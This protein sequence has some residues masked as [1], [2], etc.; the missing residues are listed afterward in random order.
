MQ[1]NSSVNKTEN[2]K[3][4]IK[5]LSRTFLIITSLL[6]FYSC[7]NNKKSSNQSDQS[8]LLVIS[9]GAFQGGNGSLSFVV[10]NES[11][12]IDTVRQNFFQEVNGR[13][14]GNLANHISK[15]DKYIYA[16]MNG[17]A[18]VEVI[19]V[20][21]FLSQKV[22][23]GFKSPRQSLSIDND[24][25]LVS[26]WGTNSIYKV[27]LTLGAIVD[28]LKAGIGPEGMVAY[29]SANTISGKKLFVANSGGYGVDS[30]ISVYD[31]DSWTHEVD[32]QVGI[33]PKEILIDSFG[34]VWVLCSGLD[35]YGQGVDRYSSLI[36]IEPLTKTI[37]SDLVNPVLDNNPSRLRINPEGNRL[38]FLQDSY[39]GSVVE[40]DI[41]S[42]SFPTQK[43]I[44]H[45]AYGLAI[46]ESNGNI[47]LL[48][49]LDYQSPGMAIIY[50]KSGVALD[51]S[52]IGLIPAG[53]IT[54][55]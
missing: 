31:I 38:Y 46:D 12:S 5:N 44:N 52:N 37:I 16:V 49:A 18:T 42:T 3:L 47:L 24:I 29:S 15:D 21:S 36:N 11:S 45:S 17:A 20:N 1:N 34:T 2:M 22:I 8:G 27:D 39:S 30:T 9:E 54:I 10:T 19:D 33:N 26:D 50:D 48:D 6:I 43:I 13:T 23:S 32:I 41:T 7:G 40:F 25:L 55:D 51:S 4:K 28:S 35:T 14:M 53:A